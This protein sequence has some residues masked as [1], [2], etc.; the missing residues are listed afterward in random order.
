MMKILYISFQPQ[1]KRFTILSAYVFYF[2][3]VSL[4][5][6]CMLHFMLKI[7][8]LVQFLN[9]DYCKN[10]IHIKPQTFLV[11]RYVDVKTFM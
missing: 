8:K 6:S 2:Q 1:V 4:F 3:S 7:S 9:S 11:T 10:Q 5:S